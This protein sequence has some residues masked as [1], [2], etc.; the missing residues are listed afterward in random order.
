MAQA[1]GAEAARRPSLLRR[2]GDADRSRVAMVE[3]FFDLV[4]VFAITQLSHTLLANL[5][6]QGAVQVAILFMGVWW[7]WIYTAWVTN[8][9]DPSTTPVR[10]LL[11]A[12]MLL[13]LCMSSALPHAFDKHGLPFAIAYVAQQLLRSVFMAR[14]FGLGTGHGRNFLR[15]II[16]QSVSATLWI[17]GALATPEQ[18]VWFWLG[19]LAVEYAG[20][21]F[22]FRVPGLGRSTTDT[23]DVDAHHMAERCALFVIIALGE[24]LLVTGATFAELPWSTQHVLALLV[25]F[26]G[27]VAMWWLYFD[28][29]A[30]RASHHFARSRDPGRVARLA[31]TY[32]H[33]LI[34][35]GIIVCAVADELSL[36]H[37][38]HASNAGI[39][40]ILGGPALYLLGNALF[41]WVT[42]ERRTPP[43]SHLIGLLLLFAVAP[44]AFAHLFSALALAAFTTGVVVL[45]AV[46][47][48]L[49][50]R[51]GAPQQ[52]HAVH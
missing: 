14:C 40:A 35:A 19:A 5:T 52:A 25:A 17:W 29:G 51:R 28:T 36:A 1:E 20:P 24:S 21:I 23:W 32:L 33:L 18:R 10:L 3:L 13:G 49:A 7:L 46:W 22:F 37:P 27:S 48:S 45:V 16:W 26:T 41:K 42:N 50:L 39:V 31:Y 2:A 47:E 38:E 15:I 4:F 44:F 8:W 43:L 11:F 9:L 12:L 6:V 34:V 30:E